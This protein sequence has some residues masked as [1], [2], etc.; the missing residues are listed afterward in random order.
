MWSKIWAPSFELKSYLPRASLL[1]TQPYSLGPNLSTQVKLS[2]SGTFHLRVNLSY[3]HPSPFAGPFL[4]L[5]TS[6]PSRPLPLIPAY[7]VYLLVFCLPLPSSSSTYPLEGMLA[8]TDCPGWQGLQRSVWGDTT[9]WSLS[10]ISSC[11]C[12]LVLIGLGLT[13]L[14]SQWTLGQSS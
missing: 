12:I 11:R 5:A 9:L 10:P 4:S 8:Q 14:G 1:Q 13:G 3:H 6:F 7:L 2:Q